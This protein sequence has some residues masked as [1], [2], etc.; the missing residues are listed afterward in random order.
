MAKITIEIPDGDHC[1]GCPVENMDDYFCILFADECDTDDGC[2][3]L[4]CP[5]CKDA[6]GE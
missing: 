4:R 1:Y 3:Q 6:T 5:K 2:D